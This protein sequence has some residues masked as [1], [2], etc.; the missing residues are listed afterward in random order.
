M[1]R[2]PPLREIDC[3]DKYKRASPFSFSLH[4]QQL[5]KE[6]LTGVYQLVRIKH[7]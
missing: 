7:L 2:I 4:K 6:E 3:Y 1:R 5:E